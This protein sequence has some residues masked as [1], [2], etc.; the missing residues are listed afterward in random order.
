MTK[1][2]PRN[3]S[4]ASS[5]SSKQ[6]KTKIISKVKS[7]TKKAPASKSKGTAFIK[8]V[9]LYRNQKEYFQDDQ[10]LKDNW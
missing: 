9:K 6:L 8:E 2:T 3:Q 5:V 1:N 7:V 4:T 10:D